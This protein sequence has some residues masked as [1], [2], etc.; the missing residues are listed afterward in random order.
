MVALSS[1]R[2]AVATVPTS[3]TVPAGGTSA[4]FTVSTGSLTACA[5]S[6]VTISAAYAGVTRFTEL[7]VTP[8]MDT[9]AIQQVDYFVNRRELK[10]IATST[11]S[12]ATLQA[13]VAS[14]GLSIGTLTH[15]DGTRYSGRF[16]WPVN[17]QNITVRSSLCGSATNAVTSK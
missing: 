12:A 10:I 2:T 14:T 3:V 17:P 9:V 1:N 13:Y 7:T 15:Y 8:A 11:N 4:T 5:P 16:T 6:G